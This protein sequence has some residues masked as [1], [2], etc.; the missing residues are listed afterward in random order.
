MDEQCKDGEGVQMLG[1]Y[2]MT[3]SV[4]LGNHPEWL[5]GRAESEGG[6]VVVIESTNGSGSGPE[7]GRGNN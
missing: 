1:I 5:L 2:M 3:M 6:G 7:N 4:S